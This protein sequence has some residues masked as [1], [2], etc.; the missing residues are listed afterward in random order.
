MEEHP[1]LKPEHSTPEAFFEALDADRK[2]YPVVDY[3]LRPVFMGCYTSQAK[4]KR[5]HRNLENRLYATEKILSAAAAQG[6]MEYPAEKVQE[7]QREL[8]FSE[9]HDIL[10]GTTS[11]EG[12]PHHR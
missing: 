8:L 6:L 5:L 11:D 10:P 7:A 12:D 1:E 3:D 4:V 9:F 2:D